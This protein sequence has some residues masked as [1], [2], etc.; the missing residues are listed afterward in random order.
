[1]PQVVFAIVLDRTCFCP[2][3]TWSGIAGGNDLDAD[4]RSCVTL[5]HESFSKLYF[6]FLLSS[7][8][9]N[10]LRWFQWEALLWHLHWQP[11]RHFVDP[12]VPD[13]ILT[14]FVLRP[15]NV[16]DNL[17]SDFLNS[18]TLKNCFHCGTFS[19]ISLFSGLG[20]DRS[21][22]SDPLSHSMLHKDP[23]P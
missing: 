10:L 23:L 8:R 9:L 21:A 16:L 4:L 18:L 19:S 11:L 20:V 1:M 22:I 15:S 5:M 14:A 2:P 7:A 6:K 3:L 13:I 12:T 17:I